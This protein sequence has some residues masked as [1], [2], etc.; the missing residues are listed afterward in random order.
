M[1]GLRA[2]YN[3]SCLSM[4]HVSKISDARQAL[5]LVTELRKEAGPAGVQDGI[6]W[7]FLLSAAAMADNSLQHA[8]GV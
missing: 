8:A 1:F 6:R 7:P 3:T 4:K 5:W 2:C